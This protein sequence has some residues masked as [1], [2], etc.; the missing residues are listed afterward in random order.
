MVHA[1]AWGTSPASPC[2]ATSARPDLIL[3]G[4]AEPPAAAE[5]AKIPEARRRLAA[6]RRAARL[7]GP[8]SEA[9]VARLLAEFQ[10]RGGRVTECPPAHLAPVNNGAGRDA[11]RWTV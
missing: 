3:P 5:P 8:P 10:A 2:A 11:S 6:P 9:D 1:S 4:A 7:A